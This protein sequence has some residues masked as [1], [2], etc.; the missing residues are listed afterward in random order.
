MRIVARLFALVL[1]A[2]LAPAAGAAE[3]LMFETAGCPYC[4]RW[5]REIG[6]IY[7]RTAEGKRAPLRRIDMAKP[8][9]ADV[10]EIAGIVYSPTFVLLDDRGREV[11]RIVGY[12]GDESFWSQMAVLIRKLD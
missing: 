3:L 4:L 2:A 11:G 6:P 1:A 8:R 9:P 5:N 12:S 7:P 10:P